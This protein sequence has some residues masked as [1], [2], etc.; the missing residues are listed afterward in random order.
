M[1]TNT[2]IDENTIPFVIWLNE[3]QKLRDN[4]S[5]YVLAK[6]GKFSHSALSRARVEGIAPGW[7]ICVKIAEA[8]NVSPITVFRKAELLPPGDNEHA[9]FEDWMYLINK[10][11]PE[12]QEEVRKIIEMKIERRQKEDR[13]S[14]ASS[15][16][17]G[18]EKKK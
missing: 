18:K 12:E 6:K 14:R 16:K 1:N 7:E 2:S 11:P 8:L 17:E 4:M 10:L 9:S 13:S 5:D 15:F 3:Q